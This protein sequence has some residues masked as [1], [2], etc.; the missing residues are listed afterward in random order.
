MLTKEELKILEIFRKDILKEYGINEIKK[1]LNKKSYNWVYLAVK[2][3]K[4]EGLINIKKKSYSSLCSLNLDN[5]LLQ[6]YLSLL[7]K[8]KAFA[9]NIPKENIDKLIETIPLTYFTFI[10]T[11][12]YATNKLRT[13]KSDLDVVVIVEE[14]ANTKKV[15]NSLKTKGE[16]MIPEVHPYVF[17]KSQFLEMLLNNEKNYGKLIFK[18]RLILYG[19]ENYYR[20]IKE[21]IKNG[22]KG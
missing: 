3:F 6:C 2:K 8:I 22:F 21:A 15:L 7:E 4:K 5:R 1:E 17:T 16:L 11:G 13:N 9:M 20:I 18:K 10:I 19:V 14:E 12:S